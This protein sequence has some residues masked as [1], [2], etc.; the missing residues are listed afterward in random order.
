MVSAQ[1]ILAYSPRGKDT[2]M[3][4]RPAFTETDPARIRALI[5]SNSFGL[6]VTHSARGMEASH[7]PFIVKPMGEGFVLSGHLAA[8]NPQCDML[9]GGEALAIFSGPHAYISPGWYG[10]QPSV[11]TWDFAAVHVT[12]RLATVPD[13]AEVAVDMQAM[14]AID[15]NGFDVAGMEPGFRARMI[16]GVRAFVLHPAR[17]EGQWKMS[18]NRSPGDRTRVIGAL[19]QQGDTMSMAVADL[20]AETLPG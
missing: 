13:P 18:Q 5:E 7:I 14:A 11:P 15:P 9:D 6:L 8:G 2:S 16:G 17:V 10:V 12:G 20:I 3:Y 4:L 1:P 19:R